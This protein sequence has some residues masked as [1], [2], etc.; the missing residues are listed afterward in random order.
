LSFDLS[1][2]SWRCSCTALIYCSWRPCLWCS[3]LDENNKDSGTI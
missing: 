3:T 2:Y 1:Y